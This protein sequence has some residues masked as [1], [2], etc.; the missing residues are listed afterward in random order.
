MTA[1]RTG[2]S[3]MTRVRAMVAAAVVMAS[4]VAGAAP[5]E[6]GGGGN[7]LP[8][9]AKPHGYSLETVSTKLALFT[10][11]GNNAADLPDIPFQV[12]YADPATETFDVVDG[13]VVVRGGNHFTIGRGDFSVVPAFDVT[14]SPPV[15]GTFPTTHAQAVRYVFDPG[16]IGAQ[17]FEVVVDGRSTPLG[18][19]YLAGPVTT[20]LADGGTHIATVLAFLSPMSPGSHTV[21]VRGR[22]AGAL[23]AQTGLAFADVELTYQVD[24]VGGHDGGHVDEGDH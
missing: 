22:L 12:L 6:A 16:Q 15:L 7:V 13:G 8:P 4:I 18:P 24:V 9:K 3:G 17:G 20:P 5:G 19:A 23:F 21:V 11:G 1:V 2:A 14:D 10:T